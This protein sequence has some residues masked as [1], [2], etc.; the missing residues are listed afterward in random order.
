[1]KKVSFVF[2]LTFVAML[3]TSLKVQGAIKVAVFV[4]GDLTKVQKEIVNSAFVSRLSMTKDYSIYE[5]SETFINAITREHDYEVS[6]EV[7][8][9]QIRKIANKHGV[10]YV[11]AVSV[12]AD[13]SSIFMSARLINIETGKVEK[14]VTQDRES[15]DNKTLKNMSNNVAYRLINK[16]SK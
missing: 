5:R 4:E 11:I 9:S 12:A 13:D 15:A 10:D 3:F 8:E 1:M 14:A 7:D 16:G 6:G 2:L